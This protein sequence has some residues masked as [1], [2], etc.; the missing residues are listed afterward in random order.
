M[1]TE[2]VNIATGVE[3]SSVITGVEKKRFRGTTMVNIICPSVYG[4]VW[5]FGL[6]RSRWAL[7]F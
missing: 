1:G 2:T 5:Y 6:I 4:G 7:K 3:G